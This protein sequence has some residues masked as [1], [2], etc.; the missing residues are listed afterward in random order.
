M[1]FC[2]KC[3][4]RLKKGSCTKCG[5]SEVSKVEIKKSTSELDKSFTVFDENDE[6]ETLPTIKKEC[7]KCGH[8]QAVWWML[9]TRSA[10][11][12]TTQF[13]RCVKCSHTWRDYS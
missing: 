11:E 8:D 12:P 2:P 7:E 5:Y 9:Q 13:Y 4:L 6:K 1:Q 10:D 3:N